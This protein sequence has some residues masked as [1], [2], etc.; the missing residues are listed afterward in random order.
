MEDFESK[1]KTLQE[2]QIRRLQDK[3]G[4]DGVEQYH[5][6]LVTSRLTPK[7]IAQACWTELKRV[8]LLKYDDD[9]C[10]SVSSNRLD[11]VGWSSQHIKNHMDRFLKERMEQQNELFRKYL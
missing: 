8:S 1:L 4:H 7:D 3:K 6:E 10:L 9:T 2:A 11:G 5:V